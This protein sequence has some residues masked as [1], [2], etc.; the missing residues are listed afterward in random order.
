VAKRPDS[1]VKI[2]LNS[3]I[4]EGGGDYEFNNG[5]PLT[6]PGVRTPEKGG[7][8][9]AASGTATSGLVKH[10]RP[11]SFNNPTCHCERSEAISLSVSEIASALVASQ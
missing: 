3:R 11:R 1:E 9:A 2:N 4:V 10:D 7:D 6:D 5:F 8:S